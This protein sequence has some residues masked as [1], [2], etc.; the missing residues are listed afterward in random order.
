[1]DSWPKP[2]SAGIIRNQYHDAPAGFTKFGGGGKVVRETCISTVPADRRAADVVVAYDRGGRFAG[3][4][5][6]PGVG[7]E[8]LHCQNRLLVVSSP[9]KGFPPRAWMYGGS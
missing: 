6:A 2:P 7:D 5:P 3:N 9:R 1:V 4:G 8:R